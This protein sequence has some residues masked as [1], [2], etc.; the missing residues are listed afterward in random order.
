M[1]FTSELPRRPET[2]ISNTVS[3]EQ[4]YD[5][6]GK[7]TARTEA[8]IAAIEESLSRFP[9]WGGNA[10]LRNI[11]SR[12]TAATARCRMP[13]YG[14]PGKARHPV[15]AADN[16]GQERHNVEFRNIGTGNA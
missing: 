6:S 5:E 12:L 14:Y 2:S 4:T 3:T 9:S 11:L 7:E 15:T 1:N 13:D 10:D 8:K 16:N